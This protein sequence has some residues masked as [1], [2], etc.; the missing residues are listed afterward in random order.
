MTEWEFISALA[1]EADCE[2]LLDVNNVYVSS[3]NHGFDAR[4]FLE[5]MPAARVKQIHLAGHS[6]RGDLLIDTHDRAVPQVVWDLYRHTVR[7]LGQVHTMIERD[8]NIPGLAELIAELERAREVAGDP[9]V[10]AA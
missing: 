7:R 4:E 2:L 5:A 8:G 6:R 1:A 9:T 10:Q 3:V